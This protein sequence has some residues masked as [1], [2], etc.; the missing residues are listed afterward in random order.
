[1]CQPS[2]QKGSHLKGNLHLFNLRSGGS[3]GL[4]L[5]LPHPRGVASPS[6][7]HLHGIAFTI[8]P[9]W[10]HP[11]APVGSALSP[12]GLQALW[13]VSRHPPSAPDPPRLSTDLTIAS[14]TSCPLPTP[15]PPPPALPVGSQALPTRR[16][17]ILICWFVL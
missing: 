7:H 8:S 3:I 1:M 10:H 5:A 13:G 4:A 17:E 2:P 9:A 11:H 14:G 12:L 6:R 16:H 15:S